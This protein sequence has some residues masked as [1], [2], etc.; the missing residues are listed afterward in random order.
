MP[1]LKLV[2]FE[3]IGSFA[4]GDKI[5]YFKDAPAGISYAMDHL[6]PVNSRRTQNGTLITQAIRYNKKVL[7]LTITFYDVTLRTYFESLHSSGLRST[8]TIWVENPTT[9]VVEEEFNGIIQILNL[10][11]D[12]DQSGNVRTLTMSLAEA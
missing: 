7:S 5:L 2:E 1:D 12:N 4:L 3:P 8:L 11:E 6:N 10:S 9:F